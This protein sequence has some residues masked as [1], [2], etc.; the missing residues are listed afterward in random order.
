MIVST[1]NEPRFA[2]MS[3]AQIVPILAD[4]EQYLASESTLYRIEGSLPI[5]GVPRP[6]RTSV[7]R[8]LKPPLR[9]RSGHGI[10]PISPRPSKAIFSICT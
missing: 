10:S 5:V 6:R 8:R 1:V 9:I 7:L 4:E 2:S 3:P